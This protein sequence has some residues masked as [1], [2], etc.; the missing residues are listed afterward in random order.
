VIYLDFETRSRAD[1]K[2]GQTVYAEDASTRVLCASW[3][4]DNG[5]VS[6]WTGLQ[7]GNPL[8]GF[9]DALT[10]GH[11]VEAHNAGFERAIVLHSWRD[12]PWRNEMLALLRDPERWRCSAA[13]AASFGLPR[14]LAGAAQALRLD[15]LKDE[16]G[17]FLI[18]TLCKPQKDGGWNEDVELLAELYR[19]CEQDVRTE[20]AVA[21]SLRPLSPSEQ[22]L[23][24]ADRRMNERGFCLDVNF[25]T[26]ALRLV[27]AERADLNKQLEQ[28]TGGEVERGTQRARFMA[29]AGSLG[30]TLPNTKAET[31]K[32]LVKSGDLPPIVEEATKIVQTVNMTSVAKFKAAVGATCQDG[33]MRDTQLYHGANTGRWTG[34]GLQ[35]HNLPRG[36]KPAEADVIAKDAGQ[37]L[38]VF[39]L[40][41]GSPTETLS[42]AVRGLITATP[43]MNL[44]VA[45]YS[46]IE[47][48]VLCW[49]AG[50]QDALDLFASGGDVYKDMACSIYG[51]GLDE[52]DH[53]RRFV[54]KQA[55]LGLGYGMG[56]NT[57]ASN[58][59]SMGVKFGFDVGMPLLF[60]KRVVDI[61]R[62][63]KYKDVSFFW[64]ALNDAAVRAVQDPGSTHEVGDFLR[65]GMRGRFLHLRLPSGR[66][67]SYAEPQL[68]L[69]KLWYFACLNEQN[70]RVS[71]MIRTKRSEPIPAGRAA[72]TAKDRGWRILPEEPG[73]KDDQELTYMTARGTG[74]WVREGTYGGKL[75]EN[76]TQ[77]AARDVLAEA[78]VRA[79]DHPVFHRALLLVHDEIVCEAAPDE[80]LEEFNNLVGQAP[81]W[82]E[83]L[84]M[85]VEGWQGVRY[86]KG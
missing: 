85:G 17:K 83:G 57:F 31:L 7:R 72:Q 82:A 12:M 36:V 47:A 86:G 41:H 37:D 70:E 34:K 15:T 61:Y 28:I 68:A 71:L 32:V 75:A 55:V 6:T 1:I 39:R 21:Q 25:A 14:A 42:A 62:R 2:K 8:D 60:F 16:R 77:A 64:A 73:E 84:P 79:D 50:Q 11:E 56:A 18:R 45:D 29:W 53:D 3:A 33:R 9:M 22:R 35:P 81:A 49:L 19:Y 23:W 69:R 48:R 5:D 51:C 40:L 66:L 20:R 52:I 63:E 80:S 59:R 43:G 27:D 30:V 26:N 76:A 46:A 13:I 4:V 58:T 78:L 65:F 54:G 38:E 10:D 67:L 24:E 44:F 74:H